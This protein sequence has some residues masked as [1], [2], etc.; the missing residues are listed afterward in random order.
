MPVSVRRHNLVRLREALSLTQAELGVSAGRAE[1]TIRA[2]EVG[3]LPLSEKLAQM[4]AATTGADADWLLRNDLSEPMPPLKRAT[5]LFKPADM[6]YE[7]Y[8]GLLQHLFDRLLVA[9]SRLPQGEPRTWL[10][11]LLKYGLEDVIR[12]E[13]E[14]KPP[15]PVNVGLLEF[16]RR[17]PE[18]LDPDLASWIDRKSVV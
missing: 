16:F 12:I 17:H 10:Q 1:T 8:C 15:N 9:L 14:P 18:Y 2:I 4:I 6:A 11:K 5:L 7:M 13:D 3:K